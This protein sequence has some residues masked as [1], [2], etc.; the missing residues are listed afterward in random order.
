MTPKDPEQAL[1]ALYSRYEQA[2]D[3]IQKLQKEN[4]QLSGQ[5]KRLSKT[6]VELYDI[7]E[8]LDAQM[9]FYRR[10]Y[11]V[12]KQFTATRELMEI[13]EIC[14][15]FVLYEINFERCLIFMPDSKEGVYRVQAMDGYYDEGKRPDVATLCLSAEDPLLRQLRQSPHEIICAETCDREDLP[16]LGLKLDMA[17]YIL[18]PLAG[19]PEKP[20]GFLAAGNTAEMKS[21]QARVLAG[22]DAHVGLTR[23][24]NHTSVAINNAHFYQA[25]VE[26]EKK[27]RALFEDSRDAIFIC[28]RIGKMM[29][30]NQAMLDLF[31]YTR[32][33]MMQMN[34]WDTDMDPEDKSRFVRAAGPAG[35]VKDLDV[36][37]QKKNGAPMDCLVTA[38]CRRIDDG[39]ILVYQGIVRDITESKRA[40][41]DLRKYQEHLME[42]VEERTAELAEATREAQ[43]ARE[44]ADAANEAKS[45]F[46]AN[47][48]HELRTPM[49]AVI[50]MTHLALKTDL[51]P[52][53]AD[54]LGKIQSS[55]HSL[56]GIIN[57]ILDFSKIEAGKLDMESIDFNLDDVLENLTHLISGKAQEKK[58]LE[59]LFSIDPGAPRRLVG[60]PL[61]LGQVLINLANNAVKFTESGEIVI[62]TELL[63]QERDRVTLRFKV[64]DTGLGLTREQ[65]GR[66]FQPFTQAD[67]ST[68]R[69]FGGTGLGL[70][71]S[72]RLVNLMQGD[73]RVESEPGLGSSFIFTAVFGCGREKEKNRFRPSPDLRGM[74]V[75]VVDDNATSREILQDILGSFSFETTLASSGEEGLTEIEN[76]EKNHP[77]E[78]VIM[79]YK[80]P[81]MNGIQAAERIKR[82]PRL[83]KVPAIV[84]VTNYGNEEIM[85]QADEAGLDGFLLKPVNPSVL[86]DAVMQAVGRDIPKVSRSVPR[87]SQESGPLRQIRGARVLLVEDNE[88]NQQVA[89]EILESAGLHVSLANNGREAVD[90]VKKGGHDAVL[91]D[92]QMP[93]MDGYTATREIRKWEEPFRTPHD[94]RRIPIIAMTAHALAGDREKSLEA[95]MDDHVTKPIDPEVLFQTLLKW[96]KPVAGKRVGE[97]NAAKIET[98]PFVPEGIATDFPKVDGIDVTAGL[99]R[100]LGN[101]TSYRRIL[102]KFGRDFENAADTLKNLVHNKK[103]NDAEILAHSLKGAGANIGAEGL[104]ATAAAL[105]TLFKD[106]GKTLPDKAFGAFK[107][108]LHRVI[109]ALR[110]LAPDNALSSKTAETHTP[111]HPHMAKD[112]AAR[113]RNAV[114]IGDVTELSTMGAEMATRTDSSS[115][116]GGKI[117]RLAEDFDFDGLMKLAE[118]LAATA[119]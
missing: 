64:R 36:R 97:E 74:K 105:E 95:D 7:Q 23:L 104:Q 58:D 40:E 53:Q 49:N 39:H 99:K 92:V 43:Q 71:I 37:L 47:M 102:L 84:M 80:M 21:F 1:A 35:S 29:D 56:L 8:Q 88:I 59:V 73:I 106:G 70:T 61:R 9:Q 44:A 91:M 22:G 25:L 89:K 28:D 103:Y 32:S 109:T 31:G 34:V 85:K 65:A 3:Q 51:T 27:Y 68:T 55:A 66:L 52:K 111:L 57:D 67:A 118:T 60:D 13:M 11:E 86:F 4:L 87:K 18:L 48:S 90:A 17:E 14:I 119:Q 100:L 94:T 110:S 108:E 42:L 6:E 98:K 81:G 117:I 76:A 41:A 75:L 69:K 19:E 46:L 24:V 16:A 33:E 26:N 30:A 5:V 93:V 2:E 107:Q 50:G 96:L 63:S 115:E 77:Y 54:Y 72:K 113:I 15:R 82:H 38:T 20:L 10:L 12:G 114:E 79:D 116:Y 101:K 62:S 78:L 83:S 112:M 45:T